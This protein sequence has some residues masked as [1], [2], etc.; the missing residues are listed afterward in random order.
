MGSPPR[1]VEFR[2]YTLK[3]GQ[4]AAFHRV[5]SE[6]SLP[7]LDRAGID[8]VAFGP[9]VVEESGYY[10]I[11]SFASGEDLR[12]REEAFYGSR[13]WRLGPRHAVLD[14]IDQYGSAAIEL[15]TATVEGLRR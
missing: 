9:S 12:R 6:E 3:P 1:V 15:D 10:L 7:L 8:V 11:R 2:C 4:A 13:A 5:V 14:C